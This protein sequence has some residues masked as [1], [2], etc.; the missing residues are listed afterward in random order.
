MHSF[1]YLRGVGALLLMVL[2]V[3]CSDASDRA[4]AGSA[5]AS[6]AGSTPSAAQAAPL[7]T[8]E[9]VFNR[10]CASCH[11]SGLAGAVAVGD[12]KWQESAAKGMDVLVQ[13]A[14]QGVPPAM[15]PMGLCSRCRDEELEAAINY[16][17]DYQR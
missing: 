8:G 9:Q 16:M 4:G 17:I 15:P 13:R 7:Q 12:P 2:A 6:T 1:R 3:G 14:R 5:G 11:M 10:F